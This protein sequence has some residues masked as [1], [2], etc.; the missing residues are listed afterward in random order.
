MARGIKP[1]KGTLM[2]AWTDDDGTIHIYMDDDETQEVASGRTLR[3]I[4]PLIRGGYATRLWQ[5]I[6]SSPHTYLSED[7][8]R[9]INEGCPDE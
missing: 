9:W 6:M 3:N 2:H 5:R 8:Q 1:Q 7:E 4:A